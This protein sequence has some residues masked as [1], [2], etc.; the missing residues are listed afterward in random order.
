MLFV[1][2]TSVDA[3]FEVTVDG[4]VFVEGNTVVVPAGRV[5]CRTVSPD[6]P[7][8]R[9]LNIKVDPDPKTF[10]PPYDGPGVEVDG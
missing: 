2:T 5:G 3:T 9:R 7:L 6:A 1:N 8:R 10:C 4:P